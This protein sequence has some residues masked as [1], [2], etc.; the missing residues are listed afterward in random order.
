MWH[1]SPIDAT[2]CWGRG[3]RV[4]ILFPGH[5]WA[6]IRMHHFK[7]LLLSVKECCSFLA[8]QQHTFLDEIRWGWGYADCLTH[9][10]L[11]PENYVCF[12]TM[13]VTVSTQQSVKVNLIFSY[14]AKNQYRSMDHL[15][16]GST[17]KPNVFLSVCRRFSYFE[18]PALANLESS[19]IF[20]FL[21]RLIYRLEFQSK[22]IFL[23][24][25]VLQLNKP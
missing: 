5:W 4:I 25:E 22:Y 10:S 13:F 24:S 17:E 20:I 8:V 21:P 7:S 2:Q 11:F 14:Q 3:D 1:P 18:K 15:T 9:Q 6:F 12:I 23:S 16:P 19:F